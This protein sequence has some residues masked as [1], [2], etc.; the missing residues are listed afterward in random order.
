MSDVQQAA[1]KLKLHDVKLLIRKIK[2][3]P[4]YLLRM[5][6]RWKLVMQCIQ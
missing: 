6:K 5:Q 4:R 1:F 2:L 3:T